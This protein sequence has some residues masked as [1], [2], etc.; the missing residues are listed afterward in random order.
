MNQ[1]SRAQ[2]SKGARAIT[3][4]ASGHPSVAS[5][6]LSLGRPWRRRGRRILRANER[7]GNSQPEEVIDDVHPR[8]FTA[9]DEEVRKSNGEEEDRKS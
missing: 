5:L 9:D 4:R 6:R 3:T 2:A 1:A 7:K 8:P